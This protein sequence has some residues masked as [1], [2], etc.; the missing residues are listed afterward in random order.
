MTLNV[1]HMGTPVMCTLSLICPNIKYNFYNDYKSSVCLHISG[2]IDLTSVLDK[3]PT[4]SKTDRH[5]YANLL[6]KNL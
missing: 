6:I 3:F 1:C 4:H 2:Q 5:L